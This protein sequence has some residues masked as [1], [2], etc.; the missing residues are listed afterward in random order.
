MF[1][2]KHNGNIAVI[3]R[4][5]LIEIYWTAY[6]VQTNPLFYF[7]YRLQTIE[8]HSADLIKEAK[9]RFDIIRWEENLGSG[10]VHMDD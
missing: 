7:C 8:L 2:V 3:F 9:Y 4:V 10:N 1:L 6:I 5:Q